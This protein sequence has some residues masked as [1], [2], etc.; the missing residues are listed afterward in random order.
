MIEY[1]IIRTNFGN[2]DTKR[3]DSIYVGPNAKEFYYDD[4]NCQFPFS[5]F[6]NRIKSR[7]FKSQSH[8]IPELQDIRYHLWIDS[9]IEI[10]CQ[11]FIEFCIDR[12]SAGSILIEHHPERDC[13]YKEA[14]YIK[15][16][17]DS[18]PYLQARYRK[19][20]LD[21][22]TNHYRSMGMPEEFGFWACGMF[23]R[24]TFKTNYAFNKWWDYC[25]KFSVGSDQFSFAFLAYQQ[26][27]NIRPFDYGHYWDNPFF[28]HHNHRIVI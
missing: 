17:L 4:S 8:K 26:K 13:I 15:S 1:A 14:E 27:I 18:S 11:A 20:W 7:Y 2:I 24:D 28:T 6:D 25:L 22:E 12:M 16:N 10:K 21:A 19:D 23:M 3:Q 9:N 5:S